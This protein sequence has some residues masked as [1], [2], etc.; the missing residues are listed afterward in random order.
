MKIKYSKKYLYSL[1]QWRQK[2]QL[3]INTVVL[4]KQTENIVIS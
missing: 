4:P 1:W 3:Q 2:W